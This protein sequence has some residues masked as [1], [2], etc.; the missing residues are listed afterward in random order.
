SADSQATKQASA[1]A[2][3][4]PTLIMSVTQEASEE[5]RMS[6][7]LEDYAAFA[8]YLSHA[9]GAEVRAVFSRNMTAELQRTR[10]GSADILVGPAHMIASA[11]RYGSEPVATFAAS[12]KMVFL[13][14]QTSAIKSLDDTK[15]KNLGLPNADSLAVYLALGEFNSKGLQIKSHFQQIRNYSS[16]EIALHALGM[17]VVDMVVAEQRIAQEW[18]SANKGR[19]IY[20]TKSVPGSGLALNAAL[21]KNLRQ[22]I[23][24]AVFSPNSK[25]ALPAKVA[26]L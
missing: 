11:V 20:E 23:R 6:D 8:R 13:V 4:R 1:G 2:S 19:I 21:D 17:G 26:G 5:L 15:G 9:T 16:H 18:S 3:G 22:K 7:I 10:T 25:R 24:D 12:E 14:P